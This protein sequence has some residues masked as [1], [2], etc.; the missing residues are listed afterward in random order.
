[1]LHLFEHLCCTFTSDLDISIWIAELF[2][3]S[4]DSLSE[5][6]L[7]EIY[8]RRNSKSIENDIIHPANS[9]SVISL[10]IRKIV[11]TEI[12]LIK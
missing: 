2:G 7:L 3:I 10:S 12:S 4:L 8:C 1:M 5:I 11:R 9:D 6:I